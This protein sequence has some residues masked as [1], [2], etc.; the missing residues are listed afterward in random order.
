VVVV[1]V[2]EKTPGPAMGSVREALGRRW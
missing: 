2:A 1:V